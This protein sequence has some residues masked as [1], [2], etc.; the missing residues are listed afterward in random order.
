M[1]PFRPRQVWLAFAAASA[2]AA[3]ISIGLTASRVM[4][5]CHLCIFQRLL[6]MVLA[7]LAL[8][9]AIGGLRPIARLLGALTLP[10]AA[11]GL[12]VAVYQSWIQLQASDSLIVCSA[13]EPGLIER[14]V[15]WLGERLPTLFLAT[16]FCNDAGL[17]LLGLTLANWAA[18]LF[19]AALLVAAWALWRGRAAAQSR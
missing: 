16:G 7:A 17:T 9:A 6:F 11:F 14:W 15:D 8:G 5:A 3:I 12:G 18:A 4:E 19:A 1:T 10:T 2:A 13:G